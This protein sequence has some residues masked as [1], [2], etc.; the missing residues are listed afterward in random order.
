MQHSMTRTEAQPQ[1]GII[2][3][4]ERE[5]DSKGY[6]PHEDTARFHGALVLLPTV[7]SAQV[8]WE[9]AA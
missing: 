3:D 7:A 9:V 2:D 4:I 1:A 5:D 8:G 6:E